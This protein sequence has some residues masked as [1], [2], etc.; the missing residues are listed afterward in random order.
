MHKRSWHLAQPPTAA[1]LAAICEC[2]WRTHTHTDITFALI[3]FVEWLNS[4]YLISSLGNAFFSFIFLFNGWSS[5][6]WFLPWMMHFY[7]WFLNSMALLF[8]VGESF[9]GC[10]ISAA[11][12][13]VQWVNFFIRNSSLEMHFCG[14]FSSSMDEFSIS[15][16]FL[17]KCISTID[18][19]VQWPIFPLSNSSFVS[20]I[21]S[22]I[23]P[24]PNKFLQWLV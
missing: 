22:L 6:W 5:Q 10:G 19:M 17:G 11:D 24:I 9:F 23:F 21:L 20:A 13:Y 7:G 3:Y 14:W 15:E 12:F 8:S 1:A 18:F 4:S 2:L 16:F